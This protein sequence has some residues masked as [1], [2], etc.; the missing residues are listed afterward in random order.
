MKKLIKQICFITVF[1]LLMMGAGYLLITRHYDK[2]DGMRQVVMN[3]IADDYAKGVYP[4]G[5]PVNMDEYREKYLSRVVPSEVKVIDITTEVKDSDFTDSKLMPEREYVRLI[6]NGD[7]TVKSFLKFIYN[8]EDRTFTIE[9]AAAVL[10]IS[11]FAII[12][13]ILIGYNRIVKPFNNLSEY[14]ERL[15]EGRLSEGIPETRSKL[16]GKYI[17]GMNMLKDEMKHKNT[18]MNQ[19]EKEKQ[20]LIISIAHGIKTPLSNIKLYAEAIERGIYHDDKKPNPKDADTAS[21]IKQNVE[22]VEI[23]VKEIMN[24]SSGVENSYKPEIGSFYMKE[25]AD[26]ITK[27]YKGR[28]ELLHIP[29]EVK[30]ENN[31]LISSDKTGIYTII[32]QFIDNAM[33]YGSGQGITVSMG[34]QDEDIF[35]TVKNKGNVLI[36]EETAYVFKSFWRGSNS[37]NVEGQGIGLYVAKTMAES[38][39]GHVFMKAWQDEDE[40]E[41]TLMIPES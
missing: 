5:T 14:P 16:F 9:V 4:S 41:V 35:F 33:K 27:D 40:T 31:P 2:E 26:M 7:G 34:R 24:S 11:Y 12:A 22:K 19:M 29:F 6:R 17:W 25:L 38:L 30:C 37:S 39:G 18:R 10:C 15:A 3:R 28:A 36:E 20:T 32:A 8:C 21:K 23:L 13:I 1:F